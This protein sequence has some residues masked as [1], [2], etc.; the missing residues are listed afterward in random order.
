MASN[1]PAGSAGI[2]SARTSGSDAVTSAISAPE[3]SMNTMAET[4]RFSS[5]AMSAIVSDF[6]FHDT[7]HDARSSRPSTISGRA[8]PSQASSSLFLLA[9]ASSR[10]ARRS[11]RR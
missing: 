3:S 10:P 6:G 5:S 1:Q 7:R 11:A 4:P 2:R 9:N 8:K